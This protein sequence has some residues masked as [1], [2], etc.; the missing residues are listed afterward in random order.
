M[1]QL[2]R[3][4]LVGAGIAA[5]LA[6]TVGRASQSTPVVAEVVDHIVI[7]LPSE[8]VNIHPAKAYSDIEWTVVHSVFDALVG[9]D[10]D[11]ALL[12]VAAESFDLVDETTWH[13]TLRKGL[14]FHDGS[15]VTSAAILRGFDL[16][17]GSDS[18]VADIFGVVESVEVIDD[19]TAKI[20]VSAPSPWLPA[21]MA[22]WHV[23]IPEDFDPAKPIGSG[24]YTFEHWTLGAELALSRFES[25]M[26]VAAKGQS[27]AETVTYHFVPDSTTRISNVLS[28]SSDLAS[29]L[30]ID[31]LAAFKQGSAT[32]RHSEVAGTWFIR[33]ATD[34]A[35]FD[36]VRVR[37]ALNLALDLEAFV[38]VLVHEGCSRLA[39][40]YPGAFSMGFDP[41]LAP[42]AFDPDAARALLEEAGF[43]DGLEV[44]LEAASDASPAVCEAIIGQWADVGI[45]AE[46]VLS[47]LGSFNA[48]WTDTEA[49]VLRMASW[50]PV[51]DPSTL[52]DLVWHSD[53]IL[54]RY[55]NPEA[56]RL[57][58]L[59][60]A[61][62]GS[63]REEVYRSLGHELHDDAAAV[64]LWNLMNVA[65][66]SEKAAAWTPRPDQWVLAL[67]R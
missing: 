16:V 52:L 21:Q 1:N 32:L 8:P 38:G 31:A 4:T 64:F 10:A 56:D 19:L 49:P 36:D 45:K 54:S 5:S 35:P 9:F 57:I 51:F 25:Y 2:N 65:A 67:S 22:S 58:D 15:P 66:V 44:K 61:V 18:L 63:D 23:L 14:T 26:P 33:I 37:Q 39:T 24:P 20:I 42:F 50:S 40:L 13:V 6:P 28:G 46:L 29:F 47:D 3:R 17:S 11:G 62:F 7:D 41:E 34:T 12:P 27:I 59:G 53:G 30:P 48:G 55:A 43:G 60:G